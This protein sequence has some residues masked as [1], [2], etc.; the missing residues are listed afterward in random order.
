MRKKVFIILSAVTLILGA[1]WVKCQLGV[2]LIREFSWEEHFTVLNFFQ[3]SRYVSRPGSGVLLSS[4]F[5]GWWPYQPWIDLWSRE[6]GRVKE[7]LIR[8]PVRGSRCLQIQSSSAQDWSIQ[9]SVAFGVDP[10]DA[11]IFEGYA[12]TTGEA[13]AQMSVVTYDAQRKPLRW[14]FALENVR[15]PDWARVSR[16]FTIP[17][18]VKYIRF[19]LT[20]AGDGEAY[21]DDI[22]FVKEK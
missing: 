4:S 2:N 12:R 3:K 18:G 17:Q 20:G 8:D 16:R 7:A 11:F 13:V 5:D 10:G 9:H 15:S 1:Y 21:F 22:R 19:R 6:E 14:F